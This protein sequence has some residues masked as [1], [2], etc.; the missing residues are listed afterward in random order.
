MV[1]VIMYGSDSWSAPKHIYW[2]ISATGKYLR[3]ILN[4][5]YPY[6]I[7]NKTL[8][9]RTN[10]VP[11]TERV[12]L[13]R[14]RMLGH[15][16]RLPENSPAQAAMCFAVDEGTRCKSRIGRHQTNLF[17]VIRDDLNKRGIMLNNL[18]D[19]YEL[20]SLAKIKT[21]WQTMYHIGH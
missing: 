21:V 18:C 1:S 12:L 7:S 5:R 6:I 4:Y 19:L 16:L 2:K 3:Q 11:L 8:Y 13:S 20:R 17:S 14:W 9:E 10:T 15:V